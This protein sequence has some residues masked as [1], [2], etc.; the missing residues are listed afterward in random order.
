MNCCV[1]LRCLAI[2]CVDEVLS[3]KYVWS[4]RETKLPIESGLSGARV[5]E[6]WFSVAAVSSVKSKI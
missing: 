3:S 6:S 2:L 5:K 4:A 1:G